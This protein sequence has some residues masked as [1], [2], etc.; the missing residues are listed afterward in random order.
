MKRVAFMT[1]GCKANQYDTDVMKRA[2]NQRGY[3]SVPFSVNADIYVIN[4]CTVTKTAAAK[5]RQ[6]VN[7]AK[8]INPKAL[9]VATGCLG[10]LEADA[11]IEKTGADLVTGNIEK[12]NI[13]DIVE[14]YGDCGGVFSQDISG[15]TEFGQKVFSLQDT[16]TRI[17]IKIQD[18]CDNYC[19]YCTITYARGPSRSRASDDIIREIR[20]YAQKGVK[21]VVLTGIHLDSYG[22]DLQNESLIS[23]IEEIATK[24]GI[25]R[26]R[27]GSL[28]P[29]SI[30]G[31][32]AKRASRVPGLCRHFHLS[33]QSGSDT[34]L[35]RMNRKY[36]IADYEKAV[37]LLRGNMPGCGITTDIIVGFP[38]ETEEQFEETLDLVRSFDFLKVH[39]FRFSARKGTAAWKMGP[40]VN[41]GIKKERA[42]KLAMAAKESSNRY[43]KQF[44][45]RM[46]PVLVE[47]ETPSM[48][49]FFHGHTSEYIKV[50]FPS[51]THNV[52]QND[53]VLVEIC[54]IEDNFVKGRLQRDK[55]I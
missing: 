4:T 47:E 17:Y 8:K 48:P 14:Q 13:V 51:E 32:F 39:V 24:T 1:L 19:S 55:G 33:L 30:D 42:E 5:S 29:A 53:M 21:E 34:V 37:G 10:Q 49:G 36:S 28:E 6:A 54:Q 44:V 9:V 25:G 41:A 16:R 35:R 20:E 23:L 2:F 45:G 31:D 46:V 15:R 52:S 27:L 3:E 7:R 26:I 22:K 50:V 40:K 11:V 18:G 12:G 38:G 43:L